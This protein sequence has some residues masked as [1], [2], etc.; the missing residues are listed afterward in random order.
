MQYYQ[1]ILEGFSKDFIPDT[2]DFSVIDQVL[3][4]TDKAEFATARDLVVKDAIFAGS[5]SVA[6]MN[7]VLQLIAQLPKDV[8]VVV[9]LPDSGRSYLS[10]LYNDE[11]M[12]EKGLLEPDYSL[13]NK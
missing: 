4:L 6:A 1:N 10:S 9:L 3:T 13:T 11:R 7:R 2:V 5:S 8:V 12:Q